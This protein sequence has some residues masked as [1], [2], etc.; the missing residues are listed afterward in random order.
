[1]LVAPLATA[2]DLPSPGD[3]RRHETMGR[4]DEAAEALERHAA[5]QP[6]AS[7]EA[8][9]WIERAVSYR[10]ALGDVATAT[11]DVAA[12]SMGGADRE[13][14]AEL[15]LD[16]ATIFER[17]GRWRESLRF[18]DGW[19][20]R[21]ARDASPSLRARAL[22]QLGDACRGLGDAVR[23]TETYRRAV[24]LAPTPTGGAGD[25]VF[26][27][28]RPHLARAMYWLAESSY[29]AFVGRTLPRYP[30]ETR[31]RGYN[32]WVTRVLNPSFVET[33]R[34]LDQTVVPQYVALVQLHEPRW[35]V[36][37]VARLA[38]A[39]LHLARLVRESSMARDSAE[40]PEVR[41][42]RC[43]MVECVDRNTQFQN[44]TAEAFRRCLWV[45]TQVRWP[46]PE[47]ET[48]LEAVDPRR[49]PAA[50]EI[51]PTPDQGLR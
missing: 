5:R 39:N 8:Q 34:L 29:R 28:L 18:H 47:C 19:L 26:G 45:A 48:E 31:A 37:A 35:E 9:S 14:V 7:A 6:P 24:A 3:A 33:M 51:R 16:V 41:E 13:H 46:A 42:A 40:R 44:A 21:H 1:M 15:E 22:A 49:S 20:R 43:S 17:E 25:A 12:L 11:R 4:F 38:E 23:A 2:D 32:Q 10:I 27:R 50:D 30:V 36:A